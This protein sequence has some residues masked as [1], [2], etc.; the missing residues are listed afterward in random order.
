MFR[1]IVLSALAISLL[2][3][4]AVVHAQDNDA[5]AP[6]T[7]VT[8]DG[9]PKPRQARM[10]ERLD[11]N[12]DGKISAE[13]MGAP[14]IDRLKEADANGDGVL[15]KE[16]LADHVTRRAAERRAARMAQ[17][18]DID[19]D[20]EVTIEE[21]ENHQAKRFALADRNDDGFLDQDE[22]RKAAGKKGMHGGKRHG[23]HMDD[24]KGGRDGMRH[25]MR[26]MHDE[27]GPAREAPQEAP[28][29]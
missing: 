5:S 18:L 26:K 11:V 17:R 15:S 23:R 29:E 28:A 21:L 14:H 25:H 27:R 10:F 20:G 4:T 8:R 3:G 13:E 1:K 24:R 12:Q 9:G 7:A 19:G 2:A 22:L 16:E 6:E